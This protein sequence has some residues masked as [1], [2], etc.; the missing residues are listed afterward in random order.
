MCAFHITASESDHER[1][2]EYLGRL[3]ERAKGGKHYL[4][5]TV[6]GIGGGFTVRFLEFTQNEDGTDFEACVIEAMEFADL[7]ACAMTGAHA[8]GIILRSETENGDIV[9]G[10]SI[11]EGV[12]RALNASQMRNAHCVTPTGERIPP[13]AKTECVDAFHILK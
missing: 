4:T 7:M 1:G 13:E 11:K 3:M 8:G 6:S 2:I 5:L 9:R 10:W 12:P